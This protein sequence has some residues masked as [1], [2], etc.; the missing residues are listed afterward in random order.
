MTK[1]EKLKELMS[2]TREIKAEMD[3]IKDEVCRLV[4][5]SHGKLERLKEIQKEVEKLEVD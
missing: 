4:T 1:I 5:L 2:E 3:A